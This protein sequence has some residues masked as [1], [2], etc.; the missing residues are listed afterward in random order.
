MYSYICIYTHHFKYILEKHKVE[1]CGRK[2][3]IEAVT[4]I[5]NTIILGIWNESVSI[6]M[7]EKESRIKI[8]ILACKHFSEH[9][10]NV[11]HHLLH[12]SLK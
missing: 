5:P 8:N 6:I 12:I 9:L 7:N 1:K 11:K 2:K 3:Q 4:I 10:L